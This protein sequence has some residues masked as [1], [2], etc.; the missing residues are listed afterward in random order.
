MIS[1]PNFH[2]DGGFATRQV[3]SVGA[4]TLKLTHNT[5][6]E[7]DKEV[8]KGLTLPKFPVPVS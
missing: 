3:K 2:L 1:S 4:P 8:C 7:T 5:K 6:G